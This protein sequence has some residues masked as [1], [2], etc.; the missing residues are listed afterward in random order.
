MLCHVLLCYVYIYIIYICIVVCYSILRYPQMSFCPSTSPSQPGDICVFEASKI[1]LPCAN[2][3]LSMTRMEHGQWT[4]STVRFDNISSTCHNIHQHFLDKDWHTTTMWQQN[5]VF[6]MLLLSCANTLSIQHILATSCHY[7]EM[8][9]DSECD[10][11]VPGT[12][13]FFSFYHGPEFLHGLAGALPWP[14]DGLMGDWW[15]WDLELGF[16]LCHVLFHIPGW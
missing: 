3:D 8:M 5:P 7:S 15:I 1:D 6:R 14:Y 10:V 2:N 11:T 13:L 4:T 9:L 12:H 16:C